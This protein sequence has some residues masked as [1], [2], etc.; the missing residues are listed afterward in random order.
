MPFDSIP[1]ICP[2][3]QK[4]EGFSFIRDYQSK[5]SKFSLYECKNCGIQFWNPFKNAGEEWYEKEYG[6]QSQNILISK[7]F[8]GCH[9]KFLKKFNNLASGTKVLDIGC[10]TGEFIAELQK[11][12]C[13]VWGVDFNK[14]HTEIARNKFG[15]KNIF[16]M[17]FSDFLDK[18]DLPKFDIVTFFGLL[19]HIDNPLKLVQKVEKIIKPDGIIATS[20]PSKENLVV[21]MHSIDLPPHHLSQWGRE[22]IANLFQK[23]GFSIFH[24]EYLDQFQSF[25]SV[26]SE[27]FRFGLV[28]KTAKALN[29]GNSKEQGGVI[30]VKI[31]DLLGNIRDYLIG[32]LPAAFLL[33]ISWILGRKGATMFVIL[34]RS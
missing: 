5:D 9:K 7:A 23:I 1:S 32:G 18:E 15:L 30:L 4:Q 22:A 27:R 11:K 2:I 20:A 21:Y 6:Y 25:K 19:E 33:I 31:I 29:S 28:E 26:S 14:N 34:K 3:C 17:D 24:I 12:G 10:G 16:A 13:E 8:R